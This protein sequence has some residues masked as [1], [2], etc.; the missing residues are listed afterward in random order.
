M[1]RK[2]RGEKGKKWSDGDL[3]AWKKA[4]RTKQ[5]AAKDESETESPEKNRRGNRVIRNN[6][7]CAQLLIPL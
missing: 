7:W 1:I 3:A 5:A 6:S 2:T 4:Q